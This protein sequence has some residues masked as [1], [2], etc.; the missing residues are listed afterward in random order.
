MVLLWYN[1]NIWVHITQCANV[2]TI[3]RQKI[4]TATV[5][6]G[7]GSARHLP[8]SGLEARDRCRQQR[9]SGDGLRA[10]RPDYADDTLYLIAA[11][12]NIVYWR[13]SW[14]RC[15]SCR[16]W[17]C[18][19]MLRVR[20]RCGG[21]GGQTAKNKTGCVR[22]RG[23]CGGVGGGVRP[24][25]ASARACACER[26][27][28]RSLTSDAAD[29]AA[30]ALVNGFYVFGDDELATET[31]AD[32]LILPTA[33]THIGVSAR[34]RSFCIIPLYKICIIRTIIYSKTFYS[35]LNFIADGGKK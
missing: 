16:W 28:D 17:P 9:M 11:T 31:A 27:R 13:W 10:R 23:G 15:C 21:V 25:H 14:C 30:T 24:P 5:Y 33:H 18:V 2:M 34:V 6:I 35:F 32:V 12:R 26:A 4:W 7:Y 29:V 3:S 20:C 19:L 1:N 8:A 22:W